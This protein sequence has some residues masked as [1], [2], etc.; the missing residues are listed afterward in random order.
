MEFIITTITTDCAV[1]IAK[2]FNGELIHKNLSL[3]CVKH[4]NEK[5]LKENLI[6]LVGKNLVS[7]VDAK[8]FN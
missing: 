8:H 6:S 7:I 3:V 5:E 2:L 4:N 1:K